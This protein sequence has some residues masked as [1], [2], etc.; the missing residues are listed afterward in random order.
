MDPP[1]YL[2]KTPRPWRRNSKDPSRSP[3]RSPSPGPPGP[4]VTV[5]VEIPSDPFQSLDHGRLGLLVGPFCGEIQIPSNPA[6][7]GSGLGEFFVFFVCS[8]WVGHLADGMHGHILIQKL[9]IEDFRGTIC[10]T[11]T[12]LLAI[13]WNYLLG[14]PHPRSI[15]V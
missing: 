5:E 15:N 14:H 6:M 9:G 10:S 1:P 2:N 4:P 12:V 3:T 7:E 8:H 11:N 13:R